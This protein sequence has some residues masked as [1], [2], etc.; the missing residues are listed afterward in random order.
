M[1]IEM[2]HDYLSIAHRLFLSDNGFNTRTC[3]E[4][5]L[6]ILQLP[7][8][9]LLDVYL[10]C[11]PADCIRKGDWLRAGLDVPP[12]TATNWKMA[13]RHVAQLRACCMLVCS[14]RLRV[15]SSI[16]LHPPPL[17]HLPLRPFG[18]DVSFSHFPTLTHAQRQLLLCMS[19]H[20]SHFVRVMMPRDVRVYKDPRQEQLLRLHGAA[21][22]QRLM[23]CDDSMELMTEVHNRKRRI[24]ERA[25]AMDAHRDYDHDY[26]I[27]CGYGGY[28]CAAFDDHS[29]SSVEDSFDF[30]PNFSGDCF[31]RVDRNRYDQYGHEIYDD[32]AIIDDDDFLEIDDDFLW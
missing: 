12:R 8:L 20:A 26:E 3:C 5:A 15:A 2:C 29:D 7:Q 19:G 1:T 14:S 9:R 18:C 10:Q 32:D 23:I 16:F 22:V 13:L 6:S 28:G 24:R 31:H 21:L 27:D 25:V 11:T 17:F 4:I 30:G